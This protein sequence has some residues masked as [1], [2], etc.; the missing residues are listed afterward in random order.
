MSCQMSIS[1]PLFASYL[2]LVY[3]TNK[4]TAELEREPSSIVSQLAKMRF[5]LSVSESGVHRRI[6]KHPSLYIIVELGVYCDF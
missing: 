6:L 4:H 5:I 1:I 2:A 3:A